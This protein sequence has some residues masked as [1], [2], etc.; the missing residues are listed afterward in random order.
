M[1]VFWMDGIY[2]GIAEYDFNEDTWT[3]LVDEV[4]LNI[5]INYVQRAAHLLLPSAGAYTRIQESTI[6]EA[7]HMALI[8]GVLK[9]Q[10]EKN[11]GTLN[12]AGYFNNQYKFLEKDAKKEA[13][14][15]KISTGRITPVDY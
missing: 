11:P 5:R 10:Y 1:K 13:R 8:Y 2:L 7:Y 15:R 6:P 4:G 9:M 14:K 3:N 12:M